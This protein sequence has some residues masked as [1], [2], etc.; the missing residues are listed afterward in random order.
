VPVTLFRTDGE[1]ARK[2]VYVGRLGPAIPVPVT[3]VRALTARAV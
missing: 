3:I 1:E 2:A